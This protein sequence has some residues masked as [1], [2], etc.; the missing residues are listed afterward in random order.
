MNL[1]NK[2][3][4]VKVNWA[5]T[6]HLEH[7]LVLFLLC[8]PRKF[9]F[10]AHLNILRSPACLNCVI[11]GR[12]KLTDDWT[13][14]RKFDLWLGSL[15][16]DVSNATEIGARDIGNQQQES[17][18]DK[19]IR[20]DLKSDLREDGIITLLPFLVAVTECEV[21][22]SAACLFSFCLWFFLV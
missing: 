10:R 22:T 3:Y 6:K 21:W 9:R 19:L 7:K 20:G 12:P 1:K 2:I 11:S 16:S 5:K 17:G 13:R 4:I 15:L 14:E 8:I 18:A